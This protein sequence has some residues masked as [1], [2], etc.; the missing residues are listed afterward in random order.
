MLSSAKKYLKILLG[1]LMTIIAAA[2]LAFFVQV[3]INS[4]RN[5]EMPDAMKAFAQNDSTEW[6]AG[7]WV[8]LP[9]C[10][11]LP[12]N[13]ISGI[14][15]Y[16]NKDET[17][18]ATITV[19]NGLGKPQ[20]YF[21]MVL[22]DGLP[23]EYM[24]DGIAYFTYLIELTS[25]PNTL[26]LEF[27]SDFSLHMGRLDFLLFYNENPRSDY[28]MTTYTVWLDQ[29][30]QIDKEEKL[31]ANL[32]TTVAQRVGV[33]GRFT[34]A[35]YGAWFWKG[36]FQIAESDQIGPREITIDQGETLLLEAIISRPGKY[37]TIVI[38][39][40]EPISFTVDGETCTYVDWEADGTNMLQVPIGFSE[41]LVARNSI[42]TVTTPL[43]MESMTFDTLASFKIPVNAPSAGEE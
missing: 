16:S 11:M 33:Q 3:S 24:I 43:G 31:P 10:E 28:H 19:Q 38:L 1:A 32:Q 18:E 14:T 42:F 17:I 35:A 30:D 26:H 7:I 20:S 2:I 36:N 39:D 21:L 9:N 34:N 25:S 41:D 4:N 29:E 12:E 15:S 27:S 40:G 23:V 8:D 37:R 6:M 22:E 5:K 13:T